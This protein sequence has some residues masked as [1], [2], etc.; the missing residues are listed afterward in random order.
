MAGMIIPF[1]ILR[2]PNYDDRHILAVRDAS[3]PATATE[4]QVSHHRERAEFGDRQRGE[5]TLGLAARE[6]RRSPISASAMQL[7]LATHDQ[8]ILA[9]Y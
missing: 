8:N 6:P 5:L 9:S 4:L 2:K 3:S 7:C 1:D